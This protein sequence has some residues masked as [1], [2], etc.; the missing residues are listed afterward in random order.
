MKRALLA[1]MLPLALA[2]C[3]ELSNTITP[4]PGTADKLTVALDSQPNA[5]HV[6]IYA[7]QADGYFAQADLHV[8]LTPPAGTSALT[9]LESG[10][11]QVAIVS[12]PTVLLA[13]N[14]FHP[15]VS[16]AAIVQ[17][18]GVTA[19][20]C[21]TPR[22]SAAHKH[23]ATRCTG[24]PGKADP[25]YANG[26]TYDGLVFA[27]MEKTIVD[28]APLLRRFIQA[29]ARGYRQA[30]ADP[31][32]AASQLAPFVAKRSRGSLAAAVRLS[33][34]SFFPTGHQWGWQ[35]TTEWNA[36]GTYLQRKG[37]I[38]NQNA[39]PDASTNEL[40]AGQGI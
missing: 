34:P 12:E 1:L 10:A 9:Q 20:V 40:L 36:F 32:T 38:T 4:R 3:G 11:A 27:V 35:S 26:P 33:I 25:A 22:A 7:A 2:G 21:R 19:I 6:G 29:V 5:S 15:L 18:P 37:Q 31:A 23:P 17:T 13:R 16:V 14:A 28:H 24:T 8:T 39:T 30:Q